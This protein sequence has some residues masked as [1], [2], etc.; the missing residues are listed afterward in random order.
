MELAREGLVEVR[1]FRKSD[2]KA[3]KSIAEP[4]KH[5]TDLL[6]R[7]GTTLS[8]GCPRNA[9]AGP[10]WGPLSSPGNASAPG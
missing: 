6:R 1:E 5:Y 3:A 2:P 9:K 10:L 4:L 7:H 8:H